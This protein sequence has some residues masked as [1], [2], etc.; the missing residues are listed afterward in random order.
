MDRHVFFG[1][2]IRLTLF[3][4]SAGRFAILLSR[5]TSQRLPVLIS[6]TFGSETPVALQVNRNG[7][8]ESLRAVIRAKYQLVP[9]VHS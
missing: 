4:G 1:A 7:L 6:G 8:D 2:N 5:E 3:P 9:G